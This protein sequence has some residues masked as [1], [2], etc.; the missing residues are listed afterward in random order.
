M[1]RKKEGGGKKSSR[2]FYWVVHSGFARLSKFKF[3]ICIWSDWH[4][5]FENVRQARVEGLVLQRLAGQTVLRKMS[6]VSLS[7]VIWMS[8]I[9]GLGRWMRLSVT[10]ISR[11]YST[12]G[13]S[14]SEQENKTCTAARHGRKIRQS[15]KWNEEKCVGELDHLK[16]TNLC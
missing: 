3:G 15:W 13:G 1:M 10:E 11:Y 5:E 8:S 7:L 2:V 4:D 6:C 14:M 12:G 16:S 9:L